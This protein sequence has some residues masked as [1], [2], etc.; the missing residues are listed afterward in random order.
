MDGAA[1][2]IRDYGDTGRAGRDLFGSP[3]AQVVFPLA[4]PVPLHFITSCHSVHHG[5]GSQP[6]G[7]D[8][9]RPSRGCIGDLLYSR[10]LHYDS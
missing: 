6:V 8:T 9:P 4:S 2:A 5:S 7:R 3:E 10:S 1:V